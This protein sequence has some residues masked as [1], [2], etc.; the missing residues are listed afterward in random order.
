MDKIEAFGI[1]PIRRGQILLIKHQKGH[2]AFPKGHPDAHE[3]PQETAQRELQEETGLKVVHF[4]NHTL[5]ERYTF[6][7]IEKTVTYFLAEVEGE[8]R[9]QKAE[10]AQYRWAGFDEAIALATFPEC[11]HLCRRIKNLFAASG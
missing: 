10:I 8:V 4:L 3:A 6:D 2:W 9:L 7:Q 5:Q 11:K 1:I